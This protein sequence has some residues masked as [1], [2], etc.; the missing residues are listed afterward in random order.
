MLTLQSAPDNIILMTGLKMLGVSLLGFAAAIAQ[1]VTNASLMAN[2]G[3]ILRS[4]N[5]SPCPRLLSV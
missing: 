2:F 1:M 3:K 5:I 4:Q